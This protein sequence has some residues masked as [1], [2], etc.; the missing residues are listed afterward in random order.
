LVAK[1]DFFSIKKDGH[2]S[3]QI[4]IVLFSKALIFKKRVWFMLHVVQDR[5][6]LN[7]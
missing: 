3:F 4:M 7:R 1:N 2:T 5:G 6:K